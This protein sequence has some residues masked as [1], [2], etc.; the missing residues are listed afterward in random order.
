METSKD[1]I[2]I[3]DELLRRYSEFRSLGSGAMG[4]VYCA[5]DSNLDID[6]AIKLLKMR[7]IAPEIA[8]RFQQEAKVA[9]KLKHQNLVTMLDFGISE[10]GEPYIIMESVA[11][12]SLGDELKKRGALSISEAFNIMVQICDGMEHAHRSGVIHRDLKPSNVMVCGED[13]HTARIKVLD[14]GIAKLDD[15][16]GSI[17]RTGTVLGTP[18]YMS[19]EQFSGESV[20]RRTD[21][22]AAG[23]MLFRLLTNSHPFEG[24]T[25]LEMMQEK[26]NYEAP[27]ISE[28]PGGEDIPP[29]VEE[30]VARAIARDPD[31]RYASMQE[32]QDAMLL[33]L[34]K[35]HIKLEQQPQPIQEKKKLFTPEALRLYAKVGAFLI[36]VTAVTVMLFSMNVFTKKVE[37]I[38]VEKPIRKSSSPIADGVFSV[39]DN[40]LMAEGVV[41][42]QDL[43]WIA[44]NATSYRALILSETDSTEI[45]NQIT[46]NGYAAIGRIPIE[47]LILINCAMKNSDVKLVLK[48]PKLRTLDLSRTGVGDE[49]IAY[50]R[51]TKIE[52]LCLRG[53]PI[54]DKCVDTLRMMPKLNHLSLEGTSITDIGYEKLSKLKKLEWLN[55]A[56]TDGTAAGL[57]Y[58]GELPR[59]KTMYMG[60]ARFGTKGIENLSK[61]KLEYLNVEGDQ[62]FNDQSLQ[63]VL[64]NWPNLTNLHIDNTSIT[65]SGLTA[66][67]KF[68]RISTLG[69]NSN[70]LND[71]ALL[72]LM[73]M[74]KLTTLSLM[75]NKITDKSVERLA[76]MPSLRYVDLTHCDVTTKGLAQLKKIKKEEIT[77]KDAKNEG[78]DTAQQVMTEL[79]ENG[80][81][82]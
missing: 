27:L 44:D 79:L 23:T 11:G 10:K 8:V 60:G 57:K 45:Q 21:I 34:D 76:T 5:H 37:P 18:Y 68:K 75:L 53:I 73:K 61:L 42:D 43:E 80:D 46:K 40:K 72:P 56:G 1:N 65:A 81:T 33:A 32:F 24:E 67:S 41:Y 52:S 55:I 30:V 2:A 70:N 13:L 26:Q 63:A 78:K 47:E 66:L 71:D 20:D 31:D 3:P 62:C 74:P 4:A 50:L 16:N 38:G 49:G 29:E 35:I 54:T 64:K 22:Y 36:L 14:F 19:P 69:L 9:S 17:T 58:I 12:N 82:F 15:T 48:N 7:Q 25:L 39:K 28:S 59:V 51:N 77:I 6:V